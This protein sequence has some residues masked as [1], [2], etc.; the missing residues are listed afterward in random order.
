MRK[1]PQERVLLCPE[2]VYEDEAGVAGGLV[3]LGDGTY[4]CGAHAYVAGGA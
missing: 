3:P 2:F 4:V 1:H